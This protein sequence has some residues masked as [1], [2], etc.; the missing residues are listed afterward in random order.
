MKILSADFSKSSN[1]YNVAIC[2]LSDEGSS[3]IKSMEVFETES[4]LEDI[5]EVIIN[6]FELLN[7][8]YVITDYLGL[9]MVIYDV[10]K[11]KL[12][13]KVRGYKY[14]SK[15]NT[16]M[17]SD[18]YKSEIFKELG[19]DLKYCVYS[20]GKLKFNRKKCTDFEYLMIKTIGMA[21]KLLNEIKEEQVN[22]FEYSI[23]DLSK[24][25]EKLISNSYK[26]MEN[27]YCEEIKGSD[28]NVTLNISGCHDFN[29]VKEK[30]LYDLNHALEVVKDIDRIK[31]I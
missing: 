1:G 2:M 20:E 9:G 4:K 25:F 30:L 26:K 28:I 7:C 11:D 12:R 10:L 27:E 31:Y 29:E 21:N 15:E 3:K 17:I 19:L 18:L 16:K 22:D 13:Y 5:A 14:C 6:K 23:K 24:E 8:D